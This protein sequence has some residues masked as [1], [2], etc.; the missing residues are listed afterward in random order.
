MDEMSW[1]PFVAYFAGA[2]FGVLYPFLRKWLETGEA[3][4]W[5]AIGG[6]VVVA[7][8]GLL[9]L[10]Q[11]GEVLAQLGGLS[12]VVAFGMGVAA[13]TVG[14]EAQ[15]TPAAVTEARRLERL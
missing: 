9:L 8:L 4:S 14:H 10:P 12:W 2:G 13:T 11:L 1:V 6:K 15:R 7:F 5:K 3:F